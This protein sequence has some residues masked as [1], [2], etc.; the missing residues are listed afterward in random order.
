MGASSS[1]SPHPAVPH[2][3]W[4]VVTNIELSKSIKQQIGHIVRHSVR[5]RGVVAMKIE[6][7]YARLPN[8]K[9][10]RESSSDQLFSES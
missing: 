4:E 2:S 6:I 1:H 5:F 3:A 8:V 10:S 7:A 9:Q